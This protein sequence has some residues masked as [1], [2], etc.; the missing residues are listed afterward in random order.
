MF[1]YRSLGF[2]SF[3]NRDTTFT[4]T[5]SALFNDGDSDFFNRTPSSSGSKSVFTWSCWIKRGVLGAKVIFSAEPSA[6]GQIVFTAADKLAVYDGGTTIALTTRVFRDPHAWY[7]IIVAVNSGESGTD[8]CKIYVN[9]VLETAFDTDNRSSFSDL[10]NVN[11]SSKEQ[12]IGQ[13]GNTGYFDG[14]MADIVMI[15]NAQVAQTSFGETT[16]GGIWVPINPLKQGLTF[17][18]NGFYLN[19]AASGND[20]GDDA[21]GNGNDFAN[22]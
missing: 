17:G 13:G 15:D 6:Q 4:I 3:P 2:G 12:R 8:K 16:S 18:T 10:N 1:G 5:N 14:Y 11:Q 7:N 19:F 21:S 20:L 22:N 9:G